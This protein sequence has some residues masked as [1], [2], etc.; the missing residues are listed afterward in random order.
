MGV[1]DA[2]NSLLRLYVDGAQQTTVGYGGTSETG[3]SELDIG[4]SPDDALQFWNGIIDE[5]RVSSVVRDACW[6]ETEYNNYNSASTF[7]TIGTGEE[8]DYKYR[9]QITIKDSMTPDANCSA[10]LRIILF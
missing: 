2:T 1:A 9:K 5:V 4:K 10:T 8:F 3:T 6:I 7:S